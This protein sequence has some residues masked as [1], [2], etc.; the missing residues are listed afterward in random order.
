MLG[1]TNNL[2]LSMSNDASN[3][4][5]GYVTISVQDSVRVSQ[6]KVEVVSY[7]AVRS[8]SGVP[9]QKAYTG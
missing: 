6:L 5:V 7:K 9:L 8:A 1:S 2:V 3:S 4:K